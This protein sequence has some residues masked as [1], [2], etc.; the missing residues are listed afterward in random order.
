MNRAAMLD[1]C[2]FNG[3]IGSRKLHLSEF[4]D[5]DN[6]SAVPADRRT[7][8]RRNLA[9]GE[10]QLVAAVTNVTLDG[11]RSQRNLSRP[12]ET[13]FMYNIVLHDAKLL[14]EVGL[15]IANYYVWA[16]VW[17]RIVGPIPPSR[18]PMG[19]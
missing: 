4:S 8:P 5:T 15:V 2:F 11:A 13:G 3:A 16:V 17:N 1:D 9:C 19:K 18:F 6:R 12:P 14:A 7:L 10:E